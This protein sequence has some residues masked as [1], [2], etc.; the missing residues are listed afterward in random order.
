VGACLCCIHPGNGEYLPIRDGAKSGV[1]KNTKT[2]DAPAKPKK[3]R[4]I[5][6]KSTTNAKRS[7][8]V[9][10]KHTQHVIIARDGSGSK[11]INQ[12]LVCKTLDSGSTG[13]VKLVLDTTTQE[14]YVRV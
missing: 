8:K 4:L 13:K 10:V 5:S 3:N 6:S 2:G 1:K 9:T 7:G 14:Y 11:K 12:Y